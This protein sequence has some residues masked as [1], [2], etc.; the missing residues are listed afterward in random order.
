MKS[1][2]N[3]TAKALQAIR[4][5]KE[6]QN[7]RLFFESLDMEIKRDL[8]KSIDELTRFYDNIPTKK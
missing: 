1:L 6:S 5:I 3:K 7:T 4:D 2:K 8:Y